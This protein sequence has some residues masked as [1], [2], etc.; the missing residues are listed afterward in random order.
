MRPIQLKILDAL[1]KDLQKYNAIGYQAPPGCGKSMIARCIQ[2]S[3]HTAI[4]TANNQLIDQFIEDYNVVAV[5]GRSFYETTKEYNEAREKAAEG[6]PA[7]FNPLS[8][9]F[10][11]LRYPTYKPKYIVI[12]E[13][14]KL[15]EML[16]DL[17]NIDVMIPTATALEFLKKPELTEW[18][19]LSVLETQYNWF[20]KLIKKSK[21]LV[22]TAQLSHNMEHIKLI[23]NM[24][25]TRPQDFTFSIAK[26][27]ATVHKKMVFSVSPISYPK[28][29]MANM[30]ACEKLIVLSGTLPLP[31]FEDI[32]HNRTKIHRLFEHPTPPENRRIYAKF[33]PPDLR[34]DPSY[35]AQ[36]ISSLAEKHN[37]AN[38]V[39]HVTYD[40]AKKLL[41]LL[42]KSIISHGKKDK[43]KALAKFKKE[44][45]ILLACGMAEGID[46]PYKECELII[47]PLLQYPY[48]GDVFVQKRKSQFNGQL[49][50]N[51]MTLITTIQQ[52]G[53]G[54]RAADDNCTTYVLDTMFGS[55]I[56]DMRK[57]LDK[58]F[59]D[60]IVWEAT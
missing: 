57:Y 10:F 12:D 44:G 24:V 3:G 46:L 5:K 38:T 27:L 17:G 32:S 40:F 35:V 15:P 45:G 34:K 11:L 26:N 54:C 58:S 49:W 43:S 33:L 56:H 29:L 42:P 30:L 9:F 20:L 53:R 51:T 7:I 52:I 6:A 4:L 23:Y 19:A 47:I 18:D 37:N 16:H 1:E 14:H 41:P 50:Y 31:T 39:V 2:R 13:A 60:S 21:N 25:K 48:Q 59:L 8:Y 36:R 28:E 22:D 55:L